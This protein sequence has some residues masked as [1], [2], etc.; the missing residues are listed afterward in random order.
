MSTPWIGKIRRR[1]SELDAPEDCPRIQAYL[2]KCGVTKIVELELKQQEALT[3]SLLRI[4]SK[5]ELYH[6]PESQA[7]LTPVAPS[8]SDLSEMTAEL[9]V[10]LKRLGYNRKSLPFRN[11]LRF[12]GLDPKN[13]TVLTKGELQLVIDELQLCE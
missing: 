7:N 9:E 12:L 4:R 11:T 3:N 13:I 8:P 5:E 2:Q 6:T 10:H 1:L